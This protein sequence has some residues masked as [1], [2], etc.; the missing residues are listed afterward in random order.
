MAT[1]R[2]PII[3]NKFPTLSVVVVGKVLDDGV[4][5]VGEVYIL[6]DGVLV[7]GILSVVASGVLSVLVGGVLSV[8]VGVANS[9][10]F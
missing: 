6:A 9:P 10:Y 2:S 7:G 5:V 4:L 3:G 1:L 8:V